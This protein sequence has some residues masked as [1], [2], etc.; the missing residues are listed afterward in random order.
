[1]TVWYYRGICH[2][3][4]CVLIFQ[5]EADADGLH[6]DLEIDIPI[7]IGDIGVNGAE[8]M[9]SIPPQGIPQNYPPNV[10]NEPPHLYPTAPFPDTGPIPVS[11]SNI[12]FNLDNSSASQPLLPPPFYPLAMDPAPH[13]S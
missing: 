4:K 11:A 5:I 12:G 10:I 13:P 6:S 8:N 9:A 3:L 7:M 1:M 2:H